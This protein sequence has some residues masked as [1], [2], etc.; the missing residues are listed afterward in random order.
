[1]KELLRAIWRLAWTLLGL[2]VVVQVGYFMVR[3][4][5]RGHYMQAT[6]FMALLYLVAE[7]K[8]E[9]KLWK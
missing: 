7:T 3:E 5:N 1:M 2:F 6:I 8:E 4:L 9:R